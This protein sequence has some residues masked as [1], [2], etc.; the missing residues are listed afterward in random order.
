MDI[1][2]FEENNQIIVR[3]QED[4]SNPQDTT[5]N[6]YRDMEQVWEKKLEE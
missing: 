6:C 2:P 3:Q 4:Y 1:V 5:A